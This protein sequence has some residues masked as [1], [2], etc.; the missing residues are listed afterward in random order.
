M[1]PHILPARSFR[2]TA[3][4]THEFYNQL[5][6]SNYEKNIFIDF[7]FSLLLCY[8]LWA[9]NSENRQRIVES[10]QCTCAKRLSGHLEYSNLFYLKGGTSMNIAT[11]PRILLFAQ[12]VYRSGFGLHIA[13]DNVFVPVFAS[14]SIFSITLPE[15]RRQFRCAWVLSLTRMG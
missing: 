12:H 6:I 15:F 2:L 10:L 7:I 13:P 3:D 9:V 11:T 1:R 5:I 8:I 14:A 4:F